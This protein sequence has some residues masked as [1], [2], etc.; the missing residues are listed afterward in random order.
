MVKIADAIGLSIHLS[1]PDVVEKAET[2]K[3]KYVFVFVKGFEP[4]AMQ[5][6]FSERRLLLSS[7]IKTTLKNYTPYESITTSGRW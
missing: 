6:P 5:V 1:S 2:Q 3:D 4:D 7:E